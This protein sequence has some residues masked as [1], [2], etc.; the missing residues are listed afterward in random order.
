M[1]RYTFLI[2]LFYFNSCSDKNKLFELKQDTG[3][4]FSNTLTPTP[5]LNILTYLYYYNGA[6]VASAD[7][8]NDG[9]IDLYFTGNQVQD[10][11]YIN[12]GNFQFDDITKMAG[13]KNFDGWT[14]GITLVDIN[15][16]GL[17]DI[18]IC[19]VGKYQNIGGKNL[20]YINQGSSG[21]NSLT[22]KEE[23]NAYNLDIVS[24]GTQASFFDYDLDGDLDMYLL[25]HSVFPNR[26]Y[27]NGKLRHKFDSLSGDKLFNNENGKF[28]EVSKEAGIF[29]GKIGYGLGIS[30]SD[31]NNDGYPDIYIGNDFFEND[32]LYM[33]QKN[34]TFK[35]IISQNETKLGHTTHYSMGNDIA[36]INNDGLTDII[37]LDMLPE[38]IETLKT[39][40]SEF[41]NQIYDQYLKNDYRPQY[42]QNTMHLNLGNT[43]FSEIAFS[44]G[45]ASTDWSWAPLIVD[46]DN[47]G[48]KDV[49][50][51]NGIKG[52][53][54]DMDFM[55]FIANDKIQERINKGMNQEDLSFTKEIPE[56]KL[57]NYFFKNN[58]DLT[59]SNV[60]NQWFEET[61]SFSNGA[62]YADLDNDGDLDI[63]VNNVNNIATILENKSETINQNNYIKI[64]FEGSSKNKFGIGAKVLV[65]LDS[66]TITNENFLTR[67]YLSAVSPELT[68]GIGKHELVDSLT[69][70]WPGGTFQT[71][72]N[73]KSNTATVFKF[74][75]ASY[76]Y[77]SI[78]SKDKNYLI[79]VDAPIDFK[80][81]EFPSNEFSREPLI[82]YAKGFEG[83]KISIVDFNSDGLDD[84]FIGGAKKQPGALYIQDV[85]GL[86]SLS[87]QDVFEKNS[88]NEDTDNIFFD[89]DNDGDQDLL[90]VSGGNEFKSGTALAP[91]LYL[92]EFG[93]LKIS[94]NFNNIEINASVVK[95][96]DLDADG[97][98]DIVI[99]ANALPQQFGKSAKNYIFE[100]D[101]QGN[102]KDVSETKAVGFSSIGLIEDIVIVD[103]DDDGFPD[104][105]TVGHWMPISVFI[106]DGKRFK[107]Q[108]N[109][110][111]EK[112][113]GWWNSIIAE[114]FDKDGDI[115]LV[116]GNW[117]LNTR[118]RASN[119]EPLQL[120]RNDFDDNGTSEQI[121]TY[122]AQ[123]KE[124]V[125]SSKDELT[126]QLPML[127]K[128]FLSYSD[129][130]KAEFSELFDI[131][132]I[133]NAYK[134]QIF[135][136][137]SCYFEN[138]GNGKFISKKLPFLTQASSIEILYA[139]DFNNDGFKDILI[140]GNDYHISTQLGRLDAFHGI[141]LL[142]DQNGFFT[143]KKNQSFDISGPARDI[144]KL[145]VNGKEYLIVSINNNSPI[146]L[147]KTK[148]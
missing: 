47:D 11:L 17:L 123:G 88:V 108:R 143:I 76:N 36:D 120:Y 91:R 133:E 43:S 131:E 3:I 110:N 95:T 61:S 24:F 58:A 67:G 38:N 25:N 14:T 5:S 83:P 45:I 15:N 104:F 80:H 92:N 141:L 63:I 33:N 139:S 130:A 142:N 93:K 148:N 69:V 22:F 78:S 84:I 75:E 134:K 2:I 64:K 97:D 66:L 77:Y 68:I 35:E 62:V 145:K 87:Q 31:L 94:N 140:A 6:G 49:F 60:T 128:K 117:G 32:Y 12:K 41:N 129:F 10:K 111:L 55:N 74:F 118:L 13:I 27:G 113:N 21:E 121:V 57:K 144:K 126:K 44:S 109:N 19:K 146:F 18:Y 137:A 82:P 147:K 116:V 28:I 122:Y 23:A 136:L 81:H 132:K 7:F 53:T 40:G 37:S 39:S 54:N 107:L 90:V 29:Q 65:Y 119:K 50:I 20:L 115:D 106:Y 46:L 85:N 114:D 125:F 8:N 103:L 135:E 71:L 51:T 105:I 72:T 79:N 99:G 26:T 16:D 34:G 59:F 52:A 96:F 98:L 73:I 86:F 30:V 9:L 138:N 102:F 124:T 56:K 42:M 100:N 112:S 48:F 4:K 89:A 1:K 70:I 127:N 101:G